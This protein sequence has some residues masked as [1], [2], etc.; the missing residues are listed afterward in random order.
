[1][2]PNLS[3]ALLLIATTPA[4]AADPVGCDKFKWPME[5]EIALLIAPSLPKL[6]KGA[7]TPP[8]PAAVTMTLSPISEAVLPKPP[9]RQQKPGSYAGFVRADVPSAGLYV[10]TISEYGWIDVIRNDAY[11]KVN[12]FGGVTGCAGVRK[13]VRYEL[14]AGPVIIQ[15]SGAAKNTINLAFSPATR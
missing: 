4:F 11:L 5:K 3:L 10:V 9:E 13:S 14:S 7:E 2:N 8:P 12:S 6:A 15:V 1:M